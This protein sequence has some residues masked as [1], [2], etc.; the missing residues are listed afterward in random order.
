M[1][2]LSIAEVTGKGLVK[3]AGRRFAETAPF[4][5]FLCDALELQY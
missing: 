3:L 5:R 1:A 4:M 2:P